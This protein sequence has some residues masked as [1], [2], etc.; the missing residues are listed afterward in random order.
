MLSDIEARCFTSENL[1]GVIANGICA[2]KFLRV[3]VRETC[4]FVGVRAMRSV[5][6]LV[7]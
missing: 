1:F 3:K 7:R 2:S 6:F 4:G 5:F